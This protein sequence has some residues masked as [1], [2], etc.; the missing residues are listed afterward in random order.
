MSRLQERYKSE[1]VPELAK[2]FGRTNPMSLPRIEKVVVSMGLG[3]A[4]TAGEKDRLEE[5]AKHLA[6]L[7]GQKALVTLSKK[8]VSGF[9][10]REG[11]KVG[12]KVTLRGLR[13]YEFID[14][15]ITIA[16]PRVRDFRGVNNKSFDGQGNYSMGVTEQTI[17]PEI[18][19]DK[20]KYSQGMNITFVIDNATDEESYELLK[21]FGMPFKTN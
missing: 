7:T 15:L 18:E 14:R 17:F 5:A 9:R 1:I 10:L 3:K 20:M 21:L 2:K 19:A 13:M 16:L 4:A 11:M 8:A 6:Q 12:A